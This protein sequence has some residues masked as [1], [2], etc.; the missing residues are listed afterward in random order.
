MEY[1]LDFTAIEGL[2]QTTSIFNLFLLDVINNYPKLRVLSPDMSYGARLE[3]FKAFYP[4]HFINVGIAEQNL[5][6]VSAGLTSEGYKCVAI[7]QATFITMRCYEQ[8]RQY[9]SYMEYPIILIGLNSGLSMQ[10]MGNTHY[11]LEDIA[12]LRCLPNMVVMSPA[13]EAE[14]VLAFD[15]ALKS[16]RPTYIRLSGNTGLPSVYTSIF[17]FSIGRANVI[18]DGSDIAIFATGAM[19][20]VVRAAVEYIENELN[21]SVRIVDVHTIKPL[22]LEQINLCRNCKMIVSVE[23]HH[24]TGGLGSAISDYI[25]ELGHFP[26]LYRLGVVDDYLLVGDYQYLLRQNRLIPEMVA[27]DIIAKYKMYNE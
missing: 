19:V 16:N 15:A 8:V 23:E 5:I 22:D 6:G 11:A 27:E 18:K 10:F 1:N 13:D 25:A 9:M 20:A 2:G 24:I 4:N 3:R 17:D 12:I 7:A 21:L 26:F 14:S